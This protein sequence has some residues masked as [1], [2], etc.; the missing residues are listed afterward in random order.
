LWALP[1]VATQPSVAE[2]IASQQR[3]GIDASAMFYSELKI[4]PAIAHHMERLQ[5]SH[6]GAYS[7]PSPPRDDFNR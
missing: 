1:K 4:V 2:Q 7:E 5:T 3:Q 6:G